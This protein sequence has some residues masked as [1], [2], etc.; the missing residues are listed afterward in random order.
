MILPTTLVFDTETIPDVEG[1]RKTLHISENFNDNDVVSIANYHYRQK[2][3]SDFL[4]LQFQKII[5][6]SCVLKQGS[7]FEIWSIGNSESNEKELLERFFDGL[8]RFMPIL[9]SWNGSGFDLPVINYRALINQVSGGIYLDQ[10][11]INNDFKYNNYINRYH[12]RHLDVMDF[13]ALFGGRANASLNDIAK[14]CNFPGKL[15]MD[16]SDVFFNYQQGNI[17]EIRAYCET[18]VLNTYLIFLRLCLIRD[19]LTQEEYES[20]IEKVKLKISSSN[21]NHL[22]EFKMAWEK[23]ER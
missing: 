22:Q 12:A 1:L 7:N 5:A 9:V 6:I 17:D 18:D 16:G 8:N 19:Q 2:K 4:P 13:L 3:G 10:G 14:L 23:N 11:E 15:D 20:E 21:H